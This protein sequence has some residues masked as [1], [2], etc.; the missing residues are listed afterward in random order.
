[1]ITIPATNLTVYPLCLGGNVFGWSASKE[2]SFE[3]LNHFFDHGGNF[4]DTADV[5][6]EWADGNT[7]GE[8]ETIIGEWIQARKNRQDIVIG[9][10]V[11]KLSTRRGLSKSNILK[12]CDDSLQRLKT[13]YIDIYYS[14]EDDPTVPFEETLSA[15]DEL[16]QAGKVRYIAASQ[17]SA[18]RLESALDAAEQSNLPKY[19]A[20]QDHYNL[21]HREPFESEQ[22]KVLVKHGISMIPFFGLATGFLTG[23]YQPGIAVDSVRAKSVEKYQNP[24][25]WAVLAKLMAVAKELDTSVSATAL[26]WLRHHPQVS[27][28]IASARTVAQLIEIMPLVTLSD[29]QITRLNSVSSS[30]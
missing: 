29:D 24:A 14:H 9:T 5:Y 1:M 19:I 23:K 17:H 30:S 15:Y 3:I 25:G 6:S 22:A 28:P 18:A 2:Q 11:A 8:S 27:A 7:G 13:D 26:A 12:A 4:I 10:K 20:L 21:V 16:I